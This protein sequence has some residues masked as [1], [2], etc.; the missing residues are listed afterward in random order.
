MW[1]LPCSASAEQVPCWWRAGR[2]HIRAEEKSMDSDDRQ[3]GRILGRREALALLGGVSVGAAG[4]SSILPGWYSGRAVHI[5]FQ[6]RTTDPSG[7]AYEFTSQF[8][9]DDAFVDQVHALAPYNSKGSRDTRN[10]A[11][12]IFNSGG[13]QLLLT[14]T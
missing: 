12:M 13:D 5:H 4:F 11:D 1:H 2:P 14:A 7:G 6:V 9:F 10:D 3:I 8:F